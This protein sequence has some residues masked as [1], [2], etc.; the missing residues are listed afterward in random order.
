MRLAYSGRLG[1]WSRALVVASSRE[2]PIA[3]RISICAHSNPQNG[4]ITFRTKILEG[5]GDDA[6]AI[7]RPH[8]PSFLPPQRSHRGS[9]GPW[10]NRCL[11][12]TARRR[13][14]SFGGRVV[15][16]SI[17]AKDTSVE[18]NTRLAHLNFTHLVARKILIRTEGFPRVSAVEKLHTLRKKK[19]GKK[20]KNPSLAF[21]KPSSNPS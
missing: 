3:P 17:R 2:H 14:L 20:R 6:T 9:S 21:L 19:E 10:N 1:W 7:V 15:E 5:S 16:I 4:S 8:G 11:A 13:L 18:G 12:T